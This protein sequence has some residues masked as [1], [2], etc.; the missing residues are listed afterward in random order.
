MSEIVK[1]LRDA[2]QA[3]ERDGGEEAIGER[4]G[5]AREAIAALQPSSAER[6]E[7][8]KYCEQLADSYATQTEVPKFRRISAL[9]RTPVAVT[10]ENATLELPLAKI[11]KVQAA[12]KMARREFVSWDYAP[13]DKQIDII[14]NALSLMEQLIVSP[15]VP[16]PVAV[17]DAMVERGA[18]L[19]TTGRANDPSYRAKIRRILE[20]ALQAGRK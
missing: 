6:E 17:D 20:A 13:G 19:S 2:V 18:A 7:L 1:K 3:T 4:I 15:P 12:L 5:A 9:L 10:D 11:E 8:A 16:T 14:D